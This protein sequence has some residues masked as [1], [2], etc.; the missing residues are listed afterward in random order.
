VKKGDGEES[1]HGQ[2]ETSI[3]GAHTRNFTSIF[4]AVEV[5]HVRGRRE[6]II[7][8]RAAVPPGYGYTAIRTVLGPPRVER[9]VPSRVQQKVPTEYGI[10]AHPRSMLIVDQDSCARI[11]KRA[12]MRYVPKYI[13]IPHYQKFSSSGTRTLK[14]LGT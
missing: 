3:S 14:V 13:Y 11:T 9:P 6:S 4:S 1:R 7:S 2:K 5:F 8:T 12:G 10:E